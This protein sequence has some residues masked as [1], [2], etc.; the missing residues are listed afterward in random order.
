[1]WKFHNF[2][3]THISCEIN[4]GDSKIKKSAI[5]I[6]LA[7]L[8]FDLDEFLHF[9]MVANYQIDKMQDPKNGKNSSFRK[10]RFSKLISH[11]I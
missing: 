1:M 2:S 3:V 11:K 5:L 7:A 6:H 9:S 4:F 8:N 10:F